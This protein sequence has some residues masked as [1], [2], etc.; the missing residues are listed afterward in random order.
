MKLESLTISN[1][2]SYPFI[3]NIES[4]DPT[5]E[6][7]SD[8]S[9]LVGP[10]GSGKSNLLEIINALFYKH[11]NLPYLFHE[12]I[13]SE[14]HPSTN[15]IRPSDNISSRL[16]DTT[17]K[18]FLF[19]DQPSTLLI[20]LRADDNDIANLELIRIHLTD[21]KRI[22]DT[23]ATNQGN[24]LRGGYDWKSIETHKQGIKLLMPVNYR[25]GRISIERPE[26]QSQSFERL[27]YDY[28][29]DFSFLQRIFQVLEKTHAE[30]KFGLT[31]PFTLISSLRQ[32]TGFN[33]YITLGSSVANQMAE[34]I[35]SDSGNSTKNYSPT[36]TSYR[37]VNT[38]LALS[39]NH[40]ML[41]DMFKRKKELL[42]ENKDGVLFQINKYLKSTLNLELDFSSADSRHFNL[43]LLI[44]EG[45]IELAFEQLSAGQKSIFFLLFLVFGSN[46]GDGLLIIDEPELHLHTSMQEKYKKLLQD[47]QKDSNIQVIVATHSPVF[48][49]ES[50][51]GNIFRI[52]KIDNKSAIKKPD[53]ITASQKELAKMLTYTNSAR[54]FFADRVVLVEG[55]SDEYFFRYF[56]TQYYV[57][58]QQVDHTVEIVYIG[59][60]GQYAKWKE[61]LSIYKIS[62]SFIGDLDNVK[63]FNLP[64][65]AGI[66]MRQVVEDGKKEVLKKI[67]RSSINEKSLD[68]EALL[69]MFDKLSEKGFEI[70]EKDKLFLKQLWAY[71]TERQ[72]LRPKHFLTFLEKP[73]NESKKK[74]L[75]EQIEKK[76]FENIFILQKGDL[77]SYL[78]LA[79]KDLQNVIDFCSNDFERWI[80]AQS[81]LTDK[82]SKL[83]E[84]NRIFGIITGK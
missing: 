40:L 36:D 48:I 7:T 23:Y 78:G 60:K 41:N 8:I 53:K 39:L 43:Q 30:S 67:L 68:G 83:Y 17:P 25:D 59:G 33:S 73:E 81:N 77:E 34:V 6:F 49:D 56:F 12:N 55:D 1:I 16:A 44:K 63:N 31:S 54:V 57:K 4:A 52:Y 26:L 45:N 65:L 74:K 38:K 82:D 69:E 20:V 76:Y 14:E 64:H 28:L 27:F 75:V 37:L 47:I 72:G 71:L 18:H 42:I 24:L 58:H 51:I 80:L 15:T 2:L 13:Y 21:L 32:H 46:S 79:K 10:N 3:E 19:K 9:I 5:I 50:T 61:L 84:I 11:F 29:T 62:V 70:E 66:D 22:N 35:N